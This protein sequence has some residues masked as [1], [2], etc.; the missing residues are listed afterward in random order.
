MVATPLAVVFLALA[1]VSTVY[2]VYALGCV[3]RFRRR[4]VPRSADLPP[5]TILKPLC[6]AHPA[7]YESLRSFCEQDYPDVQIVF[8]VRDPADPAI[9]IVQRLMNEYRACHLKLVVNERAVSVNPKVSNLVNLFA[10]AEHVVLVVA[11]SDIR[12][13]PD[14][15]RAV[16]A[17]LADPRIGLVTC[18]YR[19]GGSGRGWGALARLFIEEWFFPSAL[20]S[21]MGARM[22][23]V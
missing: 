17:P 4:P 22:R 23:A 19:A 11:D 8:G 14:Y 1:A 21:A 20:V 5:V 2:W 6:G 12:V 15:L 16:V 7:L 18:L 13:G 3:L 10:S 9:E